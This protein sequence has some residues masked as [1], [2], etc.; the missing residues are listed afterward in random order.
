MLRVVFYKTETGREPVRDWLVTLT[1]DEKRI[2]G[3]D[4]K[5]VQ[6]GWPL[7]MPLVRKLDRGIWEVRSA[8]RGRIARVLFTVHGKSI[9]LL[10]GFIKKVQKTP[11]QDLWLAKTRA[12]T[13]GRDE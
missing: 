4:L 7:G 11:Y 6:F 9:I 10:H 12:A 13:L 3:V 5:T 1:R 2:I 8:M